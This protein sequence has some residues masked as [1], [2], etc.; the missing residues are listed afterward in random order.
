MSVSK[1]RKLSKSSLLWFLRSRPYALISE[2]RRRFELDD[3]L[4]APAD[5]VSVL[6]DV[7]GHRRVW[8]GLPQRA[9][10]MVEELYREG[11][12][13]LELNVNVKA[14]IVVG[15]FALDLARMDR[16]LERPIP[17]GP[18]PGHDD[19]DEATGD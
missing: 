3:G 14:A 13:G 11:R 12:V 2:V 8:I 6:R 10:R 5:E 9:A 1:R 4:D 18:P 19:E 15:I 7:N 16:T 17:I